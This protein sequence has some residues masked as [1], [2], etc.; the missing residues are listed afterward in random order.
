MRFIFGFRKYPHNNI[1]S[2][3]DGEM[4]VLPL[5]ALC[6]GGV[7]CYGLPGSFSSGLEAAPSQVFSV[8]VLKG[9]W[10]FLF[11]LSVFKTWRRMRGPDWG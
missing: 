11:G 10:S 2:L 9:K 6:R 3:G 7:G 1:G 8:S 5:L 4:G